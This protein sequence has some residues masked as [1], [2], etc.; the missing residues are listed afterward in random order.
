MVVF[1]YKGIHPWFIQRKTVDWEE[2]LVKLLQEYPMALVGEIG[3]DKKATCPNKQIYPFDQQVELFSRQM[4]LA[5]QYKR[6][7]SLHNVHAH[8]YFLE[9]FR[10]LDKRPHEAPPAIM[11]HSYSSSV[12]LCRALV[13]LKNIG[14]RFFFSFSHVV[15]GRSPKT[16]DRIQAVP[17]DCLLVESDEHHIDLVDACMT[18]MLQQI[19]TAK[20]WS[21]QDT[22][23]T[24]TRNTRRFLAMNR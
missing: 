15:N 18:R 24:C 22:L 20:G 12:E 4:E 5:S 21:L 9:Y 7:V 2:Q 10:G 6:P 16:I 17:D 23:N 14:D 11:L 3:L 1:A 13:K 19:A 8:G